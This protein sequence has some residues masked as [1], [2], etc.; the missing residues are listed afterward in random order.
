VNTRG[1]KL[2]PA[3][4]ARTAA[5]VIG[6]TPEERPRSVNARRG[7]VRR[8]LDNSH[9]VGYML[10]AFT[11]RTM[12]VAEISSLDHV[13]E[14][15]SEDK[16]A[17]AYA[18]GYLDPKYGDVSRWV[19]ERDD[20]GALRS[21]VLLYRGLSRPALFTAGRR[22]G[23]RPILRET[24][25]LPDQCVGHVAVDH[26]DGV[27]AVY[28][29]SGLHRA[30][31]MSLQRDDLLHPPTPSCH[32]E[33]LSH[34]DTAQI[35]QLYA[36]WPDSFFEPYQLESGLYFG[37]RDEDGRIASIAGVHNLSPTFDVAAIGNLVT[38]PDRRGRG[39]AAACTAALLSQVFEHVALVTLD[40]EVDNEPAVRTYSRFGFQKS[41]DFFEGP[42]ARR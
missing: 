37:V 40:V 19:G 2:P 4:G 20:Q 7:S 14:L 22:E 41:G 18:L 11:P 34:R 23:I 28:E 3:H 31:R 32:V 33:V 1:T 8:C 10:R 6:G 24:R 39:Y 15:L 13:A 29:A 5:P 12:P 26:R 27:S 30:S 21:V 35:L 16:V 25:D 42:L 38:H 9:P 36:H 17:N